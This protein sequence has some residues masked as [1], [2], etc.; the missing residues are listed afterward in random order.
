MP[1]PA[2]RIASSSVSVPTVLLRKYFDGFVI[3][4]AAVQD[5]VPIW[6]G[7]RTQRSLR[8]AITLADGWNP[9][10]VRPAQAKEWL[11]KV[12]VPAAFDVVLP[13]VKRVDPIGEPDQTQEI[14]AATAACGA[15]ITYAT[16]RHESLPDY[17]DKLEALAQ[18]HAAMGDGEGGPT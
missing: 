6:V 14:L 17:L 1:T 15:T 9:F 10:A 4:P 16:F 3:D 11:E 13:T 8:R 5:H 2:A 7:G 18:V 12:E